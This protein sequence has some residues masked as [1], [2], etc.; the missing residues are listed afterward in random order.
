MGEFDYIA[1]LRQRVSADS[2]VLIG[3]GDDC[4]VLDWS[5]FDDCVVTTDVLMDGRHFHLAEHGPRRVGRKALA[6][7]LSDIAAMA[8]EPIAAVVGLVLPR[9]GGRSIAEGL[10]LGMRDMAAEFHTAIAGGDTNSWDGPLVISVTVLG[11]TAG[12]GAIRRNGAKSGDWLLVTGSFGGSLLG[13]HLD[14]TPRVH[15]ALTLRQ[16][17][18]IHAM[19]DVSDGLSADVGHLCE[20]SRCGCVIRA[21][22]IPLSPACR[23][24]DAALADGEDFELAFAVSPAD[25]DRLIREQPLQSIP[26]TAVGEFVESGLWL[27]TAGQRT[28]LTPSGWEH[29][30]T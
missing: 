21:N 5:K 15:E 30:L 27:D 25:G 12:R 13:K 10:F 3:P 16:H 9:V 14:F 23:S 20:E 8:A 28:S 2:R 26:I 6:V 1:W 24:I 18:E 29:E 22:D 11:T 19:I 7:N 4:A 17:A